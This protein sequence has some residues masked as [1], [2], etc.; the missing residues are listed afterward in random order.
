MTATP[1]IVDRDTW[2]RA[3]ADLLTREKAH[4]RAGDAIAAAR[5]R[6][7]MTEIDASVKLVG[8]SGPTSILDM[9]EG[10]RQLLVCKHMWHAGKPFQD[11]C[12]GCTATVWNFQ[13]PTYLEARG[14]SY[15]IWCEG[16]YSEFA[17]YRDFMGYQTPWYSVHGID[18]PGIS[19][20]WITWAPSPA[21]SRISSRVLPIL[22][23]RSSP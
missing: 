4:T 10:R 9:F 19:D 17:P 16:P 15:A 1:E 6:L 14:V 23:A 8:A 13:D 3:R 11:Q 12:H 5:R 2:L 22:A 21:A 18:A 20:G 7:P